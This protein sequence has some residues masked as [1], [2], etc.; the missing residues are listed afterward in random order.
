[1]RPT[2]LRLVRTKRTHRFGKRLSK[3]VWIF[4]TRNWTGCLPMGPR[5]MII[6]STGHQSVRYETPVCRYVLL[7]CVTESARRLV[8]TGGGVQPHP[9]D[10]TIPDYRVGACRVS[11]VL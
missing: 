6:T 4:L 8:Q 3:R 9:W 5:N 2:P 11:G 10:M 7:D 1:M